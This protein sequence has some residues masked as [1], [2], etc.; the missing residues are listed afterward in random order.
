MMKYLIIVCELRCGEVFALACPRELIY[1]ALLD[2][3]VSFLCV[4][5]I[6]EGRARVINNRREEQLSL[7]PCLVLMSTLF[8]LLR[9]TG[10]RNDSLRRITIVCLPPRVCVNKRCEEQQS[11]FSCLILMSTLF[12]LLRLTG[13]RS[14]SLRSTMTV[15]LPQRVC[16]VREREER[17]RKGLFTCSFPWQ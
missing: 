6:E 14:D 8:V 5:C 11:L 17:T 4:K 12:V 3:H 1:C 2:L 9:L 10:K 15:C 13:K 16:E 7:F